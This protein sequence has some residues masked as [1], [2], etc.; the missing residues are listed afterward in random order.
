[1]KKN[2]TVAIAIFIKDVT[3]ES[4]KVWTQIRLER[5]ALYGLNEFP[6]GKIE[7][8]ESPEEACRR[9]VLEEVGVVIPADS[10]VILFKYQDYSFEYK[11]FC[12]YTFL[13]N[14]KELPIDKG[15][16]L[17]IKYK[18]KSQILQGKIPPI[19]HVI[20]DDLAVYIHSQHQARVLDYLWIM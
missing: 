20:L 15:E 11:N 4:F 18:E 9:E 12:L 14:F 5:G 19:N 2:L 3:D 17:E 16:W 10:K 8:G 1:M 13:S 6:G 7:A